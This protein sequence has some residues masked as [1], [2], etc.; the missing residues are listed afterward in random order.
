MIEGH[1]CEN[2][3]ACNVA[4]LDQDGQRGFF[5]IIKNRRTI[6]GKIP[7]YAHTIERCRSQKRS[8]PLT[9]VRRT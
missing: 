2:C 6:A 7:A 8:I 5:E 9:P 4:W 1:R 3:G